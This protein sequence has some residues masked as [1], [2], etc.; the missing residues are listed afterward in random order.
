MLDTF[1]KIAAEKVYTPEELTD[2]IKSIMHDQLIYNLYIEGSIRKV[3]LDTN[4][5]QVDEIIRRIRA[6]IKQCT[7]STYHK[8]WIKDFDNGLGK[9]IQLLDKVIELLEKQKEFINS[10]LEKDLHNLAG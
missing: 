7:T 1:F 3:A 9:G 2:D 10:N 5:S 4:N 6:M 8:Q